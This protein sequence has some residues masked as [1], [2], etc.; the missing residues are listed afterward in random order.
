[1]WPYRQKQEVES[2]HLDLMHEAES[3]VEMAGGF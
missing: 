2:S 3:G 1:M